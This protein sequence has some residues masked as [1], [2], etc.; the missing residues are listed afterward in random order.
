MSGPVPKKRASTPTTTTTKSFV[1]V[2]RFV[3][4]SQTRRRLSTKRYTRDHA[5]LKGNIVY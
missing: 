1:G 3:I 5:R 4:Q 2:A